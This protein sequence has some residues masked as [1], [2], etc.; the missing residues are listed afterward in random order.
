MRWCQCTRVLSYSFSADGWNRLSHIKSGPPKYCQ[1]CFYFYLFYCQ[2]C[3]TWTVADWLVVLRCQIMSQGAST[4]LQSA[5]WL[6]FKNPCVHGYSS[7]VVHLKIKTF[8]VVIFVVV[9]LRENLPIKPWI[10]R[11]YTCGIIGW[12]INR[13]FQSLMTSCWGKPF[14]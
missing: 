5:T 9:L 4:Q 1:H 12:A 3:R 2:S 8:S 10:S 13:L 14:L 11:F 7:K 6:E